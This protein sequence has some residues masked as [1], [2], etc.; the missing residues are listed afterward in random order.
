MQVTCHSHPDPPGTPA[1]M[2]PPLGSSLPQGAI[3]IL[4]GITPLLSPP[5]GGITQF[6]SCGWPQPSDQPW[7]SPAVSST[8]GCPHPT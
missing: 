5:P 1:L 2:C 4:G 7:V 8:L 3:G 6:I